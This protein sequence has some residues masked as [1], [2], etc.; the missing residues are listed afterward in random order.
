M[1]KK[2]VAIIF[3]VTLIFATSLPAL[4]K[5]VKDDHGSGGNF[6]RQV[7]SNA[8]FSKRFAKFLMLLNSAVLAAQ[9][10]CDNRLQVV[11]SAGLGITI[12]TFETDRANSGLTTD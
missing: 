1:K 4:S 10:A 8:N 3:S 9:Q 2:F 12:N 5:V 6:H 11:T 7:Q